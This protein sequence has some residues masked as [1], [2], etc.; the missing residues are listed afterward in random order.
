MTPNEFGSLPFQTSV[1]VAPPLVDSY[2]PGEFAPGSRR[3]VPPAP[4]TCERPRTACAEPT[5]RCRLLL[6]STTIALIPRPRNESLP[7]LTQV[8][9]ELL[10]HASLSF[11]QCLPPSVDL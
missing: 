5:K 3:T 7:G 1:N 4:I 8:Y 6:G 9:V 2:T 11:V 10:T